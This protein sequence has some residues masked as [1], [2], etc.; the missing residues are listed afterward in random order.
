MT[1]ILLISW[2][3]PPE[4][5]GSAVIVGNLAKQ[6]NAD[7]MI[8]IGE[9]PH[10]R[11]PVSWHNEWPRLV[12]IAS[13]LPPTWRGAR[14]WRRLQLPMMLLRSMFLIRKTECSA[15]IVVFPNE[16]FLFLGYILAS[17]TGLPMYAY[18]H[19]T[20]L[21]NRS[22]SSLPFA[23]WLQA[24]IFSKAKHVFVMSEGMVELYRKRYPQLRCSALVHSFNEKIPAIETVPE[25]H[26]PLRLVICG[27]INASCRDATTRFCE[28]IAHMKD[29]SL[30]FLSGTPRTLLEDLGLLRNGT[31]FETV[32]RDHVINRLREADIVVLPH[33]FTGESAPE[34]YGTMFP[35]KTIEY[36]ISGRPILAHTPPDCYLTRFRR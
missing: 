18:F 30:T 24:R 23:R 25:P 27:N 21:E 1:K 22:G 28:A 20:Y 11:P 26:S 36:L 4:T 3:L 31:H 34:E 15:I 10:S 7:E 19:N 35:T 2:T 6:F 29:V 8:V 33:G 17:W 16:E 32:S 14:W 13:A 5:T 12:Y 9:K